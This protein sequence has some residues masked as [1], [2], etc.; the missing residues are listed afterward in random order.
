MDDEVGGDLTRSRRFHGQFLFF[1][2]VFLD[3]EI[4][5]V[6]KVD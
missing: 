5:P 6:T 3:V 2:F 4:S 1:F